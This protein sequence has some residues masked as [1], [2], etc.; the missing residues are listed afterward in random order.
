MAKQQ[1]L[2][3]R[4][5]LRAE[6]EKTLQQAKVIKMVALLVSLGLFVIVCVGGYYIYK[7]QQRSGGY[8]PGS[9]RR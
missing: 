1:E 9:Y 8:R 6:T 2:M 7:Y 3:F 4:E 5:A